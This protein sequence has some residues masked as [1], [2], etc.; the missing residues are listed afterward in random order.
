LRPCDLRQTFERCAEGLWR[1]ILVR[2]GGD[3]HA[4]EDLMQQT[5]LEAAR[6]R[7]APSDEAGC[8]RF[9]FGI[10]RNLL[11][12][13]WRRMKRRGVAL[14]TQ[15]AEIGS[16]LAALM[17]AGPLAPDQLASRE[18]SDQLLLTI[19][20]LP[21]ADQQL[22]FAFYFEGRSHGQLAV[23]LGISSKSV[24]SRLYRLRTRLRAI[25]RGGE[26]DR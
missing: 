14:P 26:R 21:A 25:L 5:C 4:A 7:R 23:E 13:R 24:E 1:F 12:K 22:L 6:S 10:A 3:R 15:D 2:A 8:E 17:E 19:T 18:V 9:L 16:Q 20:A 11:R